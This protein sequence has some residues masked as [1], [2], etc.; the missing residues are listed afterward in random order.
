MGDAWGAAAAVNALPAS[1]SDTHSTGS[2][3][4]LCNKVC[5]ILCVCLCVGGMAPVLVG[6]R[7]T[8]TNK[9][10]A[11]WVPGA[12][13][14]KQ[15]QSTCARSHKNT[16]RPNNQSQRTHTYPWSRPSTRRPENQQNTRHIHTVAPGW[17]TQNM[18]THTHTYTHLD[19][20]RTSGWFIWPFLGGW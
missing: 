3:H 13:R 20:L 9:H 15:T 14:V 17:G 1:T 12:P 2:S 16:S 6:P 19:G 10:T 5:L 18:D 8:H 11:V 4:M 7:I